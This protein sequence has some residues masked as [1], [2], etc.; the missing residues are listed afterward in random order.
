MNKNK[1]MGIVMG[2]IF[3]IVGILVAV[4]GW[5]G[6]SANIADQKK[7]T[8][9]AV[10]TLVRYEEKLVTVS[11]KKSNG[12]TTKSKETH[13]FPVFEFAADGKTYT[14]EDSQM[15]KS[16][17]PYEIGATIEL[18]YEPAD[19]SNNYIIETPEVTKYLV[20]GFGGVFALV[21]CIVMIASAKGRV[22]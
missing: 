17:K 4:L 11:K 16:D 22:N 2:A 10:G 21:G 6:L 19:P 18:H 13:Y 8:A 9:T 14:A 7:C 3:M 1:T 12:K 5:K 20:A 15:G